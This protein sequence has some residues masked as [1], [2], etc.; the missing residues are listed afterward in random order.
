MTID[1]AS[2]TDRVRA[3]ARAGRLVLVEEVARDG[4]QGRTLL[5]AEQRIAIA[6]AQARIFGD[7]ARDRLVFVAGFPPIAHEEAEIVRRVCA[8]VDTCQVQTL[9]RAREDDLRESLALAAG[10][11]YGRTLFVVPASRAMSEAMLHRA[12]VAAV[13]HALGL[14]ALGRDRAEGVALDVCL[15]DIGRADP[16]LLADACNRLTEAGAA[17]I[18]LADTVG[19]LYPDRLDALLAELRPRLDPAVVLHLHLHD[20]LGLALANALVGLRH[21]VRIFTSAWLGLGERAGLLATERLLGA[22]ALA[23]GEAGRSDIGLG[24]FEPPLEMTRLASLARRIAVWLDLPLRT[25]EPFVG[26]GVHTVATG[27]PF[28]DPPVFRPYDPARL[29]LSTDIALTQLASARLVSRVAAEMGFDIGPALAR[30]A[31]AWIKARAYR[32][33]RATVERAALGGFLRAQGAIERG[34]GR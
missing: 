16:G 19:C 20:D 10:A 21:G 33:G 23:D 13:E 29:G 27:T 4:A 24:L 31:M 8:A 32:Q 30:A 6:R 28:I 1:V 3:S 2:E 18:M 12:P 22:L 9:C 15:A 14:L 25:C 17:T 26:D 7:T 11:R 34:A 5:D